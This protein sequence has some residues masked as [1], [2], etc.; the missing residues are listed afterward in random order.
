MT[1]PT[2]D[3]ELDALDIPTVCRR[4]GL[5]R[6]FL[7]EEIRAGRLIARKFGRLTRV[8]QRDYEAWLAA[9]PP[10]AL[11]IENDGAPPLAPITRRGGRPGAPR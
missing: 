9:A 3:G 1:C 10:I 4:S 2:P 5:G 8:L 6:S 11:T 7:Y